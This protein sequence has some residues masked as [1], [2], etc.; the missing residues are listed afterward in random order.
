MIYKRIKSQLALQEFVKEYLLLHFEYD[1]S[2]PIMVKAFPPLPEHG[3]EF[4]PKGLVTSFNY[5]T[6][7]EKREPRNAIFGQQVSRINFIMPAEEYI[8]IRVIFKIGG[9]FRLLRVPLSNFVDIKIDAENVINKEVSFVNEQL[10]ETSDYTAMIAIV[11]KYLLSKVKQVKTYIHPIDKVGEIMLVN[12]DRFSL[13]WLSNQAFLSPRQFQRKFI[14]RIGVGPK[15][16]S[17]I[18]RFHRAFLWKEANPETDWL[19]VAVYFGYTDF[20]HLF[21]DFK[22]FAQ[23]SPNTLLSQYAQS[24]EKI[25]RLEEE[26]RFST[27]KVLPY[28]SKFALNNFQKPDGK[29]L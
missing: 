19:T 14:E 16:F 29:T 12:P 2:K 27:H 4:F 15:L 20:H 6:G 26:C 9:L 28:T 21:K 24:P 13:D 11:E 7:I 1:A 23:V 10:A 18:V 25:L 8:M 22:E 5:S 17:R 3:I